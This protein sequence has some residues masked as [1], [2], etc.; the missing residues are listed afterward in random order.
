MPT[1]G[2]GVYGLLRE[3]VGVGN[4]RDKPM[5]ENQPLVPVRLDTWNSV[6]ELLV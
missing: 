4:T 5:D 2:E 1:S 6:M 3:S